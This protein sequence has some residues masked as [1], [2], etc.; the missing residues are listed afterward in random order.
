MSV[1]SKDVL[2]IVDKAESWGGLLVLDSK[3]HGAYM[4][5]IWDRQDPGGPH[6]GPMNLAIKHLAAICCQVFCNPLDNT[7]QW[8]YICSVHTYGRA[9]SRFAPSQWGIVLFCNVF[10]HWLG[11]TL[12]SS[13]YC[14][15][16]CRVSEH[17][18][19]SSKA[20]QIELVKLCIIHVN[21][22]STR[23]STLI[24]WHEIFTINVSAHWYKMTTVFYSFINDPQFLFV[25][26]FI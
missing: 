6:V 7:D 13:L 18:S 25:I 22:S 11:A 1:E 24:S 8:V 5:P 3:V 12:E 17:C 14:Y 4:G 21:S 9:D 19:W 2:V 10:S 20:L 15:L 23:L 16:G 26:C